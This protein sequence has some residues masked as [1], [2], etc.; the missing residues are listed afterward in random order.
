MNC[1]LGSR[2]AFDSDGLL[3]SIRKFCSL[4][5]MVP[6]YSLIYFLLN[7]LSTAI[8]S[9]WKQQLWKVCTLYI[10]FEC[11]IQIPVWLTITLMIFT[12]DTHEKL[13]FLGHII[14]E[15][16]IQFSHNYDKLYRL[17]YM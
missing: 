15:L 6:G 13:F 1:I 17:Y 2:A 8:Q 3:S 7:F 9:I 12:M 4:L 10:R 14:K 16:Y 5:I 11:C